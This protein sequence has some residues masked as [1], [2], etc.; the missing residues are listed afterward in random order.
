MFR[1]TTSTWVQVTG[2]WT[3]FLRPRSGL[4]LSQ[5][6]RLTRREAAKQISPGALALGR[7]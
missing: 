3:F 7:R 6:S 1:L 4:I 5:G 2:V